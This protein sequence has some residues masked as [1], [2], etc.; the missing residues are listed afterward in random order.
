MVAAGQPERKKA[1]HQYK[2]QIWTKKH[3]MLETI[4]TARDVCQARLIAKEQYPDTSIGNVTK[5]D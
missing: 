2:V 5:V 3:G 4:I 1:M